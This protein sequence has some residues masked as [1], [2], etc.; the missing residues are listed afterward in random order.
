MDG[1]SRSSR[2][3]K[4]LKVAK[5]HKRLV[6]V[7]SY[8]DPCPEGTKEDIFRI[9]RRALIFLEEEMRKEDIMRPRDIEEFTYLVK[10]CEWIFERIWR[11]MISH[12]LKGRKT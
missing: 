10:L 8:D 6:V 12:A 3:G 7:D 2:L 1:A 5:D 4:R 9:R 11:A